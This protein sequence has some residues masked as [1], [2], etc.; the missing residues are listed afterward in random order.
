MSNEEQ[1]A[2]TINVDGVEY[3]LNDLSPEIRQRVALYQQW[4]TQL[5]NL[6]SEYTKTE[7]AVRAVGR[8]IGEMIKQSTAATDQAATDAEPVAKKA[9]K[10]K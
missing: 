9:A 7:M 6:H 4:S 1:K 8:E 2:P 10:K 5:Q 3:Q